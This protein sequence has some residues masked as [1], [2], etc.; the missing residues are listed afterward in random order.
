MEAGVEV[1]A[2]VVV[3]VVLVDTGL[4]LDYLHMRDT[5]PSS[6]LVLEAQVGHQRVHR[7]SVTTE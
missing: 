5:M 7:L 1:V 2:T 6:L 4:G 3:E